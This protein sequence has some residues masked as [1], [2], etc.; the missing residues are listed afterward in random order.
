MNTIKNFS[1]QGLLRKDKQV[2][3]VHNE[4]TKLSLF[5]KLVFLLSIIIF[6][7]TNVEAQN[8]RKQAIN[9]CAIAIPTMNLYV[10]NYEY[11]YHQRHGLAVRTEYAA[12][13]SS[14][15]ATGIGMA[16]VLNYRWHFSPKLDNFFIG[17]YGRYRYVSGSGIAGDINYDFSIPEVNLGINGGYRWVSKIGIN[18][19][20]AA[21]YGYSWGSENITPLNEQ[22]ISN[23]NAFKKAESY[24]EA[25]YYGEVSIGYAF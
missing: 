9:V 15:G 3:K 22:V 18:V 14:E 10:L 6:S 16:A 13:L 11:L 25:P 17:A 21:G 20:L 4:P 1:Y 8:E 5:C 12:D 24:I 19:V 23:F 2:V 7:T